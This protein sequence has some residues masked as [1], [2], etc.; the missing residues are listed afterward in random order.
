MPEP[1]I[2]VAA[3]LIGF[4]AGT[5][6]TVM[7]LFL[8]FR[9]MR[10]IEA[11]V[12]TITLAGCSLAW[13]FGGLVTTL[14]GIHA[15]LA[16]TTLVRWAYLAKHIS[17]L[18]WPVPMLEIWRHSAALRWQRIAVRVL[19]AIAAASTLPML[20]VSAV[21]V[22]QSSSGVPEARI[23]YFVMH[24]VSYFGLVLFAF[25]ASLL[26]AQ[27]SANRANWFA[28]LMIL[29][30]I[31]GVS[32][33][34]IVEG[35][36]GTPFVAQV[37]HLVAKQAPLFILFGA[38]FMFGRLRFADVFIRQSF[39]ILVASLLSF[40]LIAVVEIWIAHGFQQPNGP[41]HAMSLFETAA[42]TAICLGIFFVADRGMG[43]LVDQSV[44][45][46]TEFPEKFRRLDA[47]LLQLHSESD[48][49]SAIAA[50][51][52]DFLAIADARL[53]AIDRLPAGLRPPAGPAGEVIALDPDDELISQLPVPAAE[54]FAPIESGGH[55]SHVLAIAPGRARRALVTAEL[56]FL[57]RIARA[58]GR[59]LDALRW[60]RE[61]V[62][63]RSREALLIK[64][65]TEAE[66]RSL[67]AQINPH[68]LFNSL[69]TIAD[70]IA[71]DPAQAE[72]MTMRLAQVFR[73]V[74]SNSSRALVS[75]QEEIDFVRAYLSIEQARFGERIEVGIELDPAAAPVQ[76]PSLI[77][78]P[79][80]EN[81]LKHG[82]APKPGR[83]H[84]WIA[85]VRRDAH[86]ALQ[87]EDDGVGWNRS[88]DGD[89]FHPDSPPPRRGVGL[90]NV[91]ERLAT[92]Y[93]D[94][95]TLRCEAR[96]AGGSRVTLH[97]PL[98]EG[99]A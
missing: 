5:I 20:W 49:T 50:A 42:L 63:R 44:F 92:L 64:Q 56:V 86:V 2:F 99:A 98:S 59:R 68:F 33:G 71:A 76:V 38:F 9:G 62:E 35:S 94:R 69:N 91:A 83:V 80:V 65:A 40:G 47:A 29:I 72:A 67:R 54:W 14:A 48:I 30:G 17:P 3:D 43:R 31:L 66:L 24:F 89:G 87:V 32:F 93:Q 57:Q 95:A 52:R 74:L 26:A 97:I 58:I 79:L 81:A 46:V 90:T 77:L 96:A 37:A 11:P 82:L 25:G 8:V 45:Q 12:A 51:V 21:A 60:E 41:D 78:Q 1:G 16:A 28:G 18:F 88:P 27:R 19:Q 55:T 36:A 7:F 73:H 6:I 75:L 22:I 13:N 85:A 23:H 34:L 10:Q 70:L 39:R 4:T 15:D 61:A 53:L 84:L